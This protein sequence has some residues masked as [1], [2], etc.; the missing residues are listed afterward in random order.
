MSNNSVTP[1]LHYVFQGS[2]EDTTYTLNY[3]F[4]STEVALNCNEHPNLSFKWHGY[5]SNLILDDGR[6]LLHAKA[7]FLKYKVVNVLTNEEYCEIAPRRAGLKQKYEAKFSDHMYSIEIRDRYLRIYYG[8]RKEDGL[9]VLHLK[10]GFRGPKLLYIKKNVDPA[11]MI[12]IALTVHKIF[13]A[14]H[15]N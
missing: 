11:M 7:G 1:N 3:T 6:I 15:S 5:K 10:L 14:Q 4:C 8:N 13:Q 9:E 12:T 2:K